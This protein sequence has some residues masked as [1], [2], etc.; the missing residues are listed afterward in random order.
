[1]I[2]L[3]LL[4]YLI[5]SSNLSYSDDN[6]QLQISK[7]PINIEPF[8]LIKEN[9]VNEIISKTN[10]KIILL[11]F[12]ATWC[13]PCIKEIP[14]LQKLKKEFNAKVDVFFISVDSNFKES[15]PK[16]LKKNNFS[17]LKVYNDEKLNISKKFNV[18]IMPTTIIINKNFEEQSRVIGYVDWQSEKYKSLIKDLL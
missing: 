15:V 2:R 1:M 4:L 9:G 10:G 16:F 11:N 3:L 5:T 12:W 14:D 7:Q 17:N 6:N 18:K 8:K 13:T